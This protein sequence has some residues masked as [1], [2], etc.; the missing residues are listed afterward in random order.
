[1]P[2][3]ALS[4][5]INPAGA[6]GFVFSVLSPSVGRVR[7]QALRGLRRANPHGKG[8]G[9]LP[10]PTIRP[11]NKSSCSLGTRGRRGDE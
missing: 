6:L 9:P 10:H 4:E 7:M 1:M 2:G 3:T 11:S 5:Q 8:T